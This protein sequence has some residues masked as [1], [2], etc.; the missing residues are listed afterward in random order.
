MYFIFYSIKIIWNKKDKIKSEIIIKHR[1]TNTRR[2]DPSRKIVVI[3][4][5]NPKSMIYEYQNM[6]KIQSEIQFSVRHEIWTNKY[7]SWSRISRE[8]QVF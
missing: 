6:R 4:I 1:I 7:F 3:F 5:N 2:H 8:N